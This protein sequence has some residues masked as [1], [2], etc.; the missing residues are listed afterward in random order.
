MVALIP[1]PLCVPVQAL[2]PYR[3]RS[4]H[5]RC[6]RGLRGE[7][8]GS[9]TCFNADVVATAKRDLKPARPSM[10]GGYTVWGKLLPAQQSIEAACPGSRAQRHSHARLR[11]GQSLTWSDVVIDET[12]PAYRRGGRWRRCSPR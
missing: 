11:Q 12:L 4:R 10:G 9:A 8:T 5:L 6:D 3:S 2:A 1:A 7:A